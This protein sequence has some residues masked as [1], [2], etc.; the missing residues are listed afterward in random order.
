MA[1]G[2][3]AGAQ[4]LGEAAGE[5][6]GPLGPAQAKLLAIYVAK[7]AAKER[8]AAQAAVQPPTHIGSN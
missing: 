2:R 7:A 4:R 6:L 5:L 3:G 8:A 1:S